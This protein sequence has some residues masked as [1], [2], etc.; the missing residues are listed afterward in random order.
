[1]TMLL[2]AFRVVAL[3]IAAGFMSPAAHA[4]TA[5]DIPI[6]CDVTGANLCDSGVQTQSV[7][8]TASLVTN[9]AYTGDNY[10]CS[11][12]PWVDVRCSFGAVP[13]ASGNATVDSQ[14]AF[15]A[16]INAAAALSQTGSGI[17]YVPPGNYCIGNTTGLGLTTSSP[18]TILGAGQT[19]TIIQA[20]F[21][22]GQC[23]NTTGYSSPNV[24]V[25]TANAQVTIRDV[26]IL[27]PGFTALNTLPTGN[28]L[29]LGVNAV[30]SL[31]EDST[32]E[33]GQFAIVN[34][35]ADA[36][37]Q[38][39]NISYA[40]GTAQVA[41]TNGAFYLRRDKIDLTDQ[42]PHCSSYNP[43][44]GFNPSAWSAN[45]TYNSGNAC[46]L[47]TL[48]IS[49][50]SF[51][52][53]LDNQS[54]CVASGSKPNFLPYGSKIV[55]G[56]CN[57]YLEAPTTFYAFQ[58]DTN[59][60]NSQTATVQFVEH[61]DLSGPYTA[62][63]TTL[64]TGSQATAPQTIDLIVDTIG[65][66]LQ[67]DVELQAGNDVLVLGGQYGGPAFTG[68]AEVYTLGSFLGDLK[69]IGTSCNGGSY[70]IL[71][72]SGSGVT[73]SGNTFGG[74]QVAGIDIGPGSTSFTLEGNTLGS[75]EWVDAGGTT[76]ILISSSGAAQ[77]HYTI[78][79]NICP[80]TAGGAGGPATCFTDNP[81]GSN[82]FIQ[83][84]AGVYGS[85]IGALKGIGYSGE[86][87]TATANGESIAVTV[88]HASPAVVTMTGNTFAARCQDGSS[89]SALCVLPIYFTGLS[90]VGI[91]NNTAYFVDPASISGNNF[92]VATSVANALAATDVATTGTDSGTGIAAMYDTTSGT[93]QPMLEINL[94]GGDWTCSGS[95]YEN[96]V[97]STAP[98]V[99]GAS[100]SPTGSSL[101]AG[102]AESLLNLTF[103]TGAVPNGFAINPTPLSLATQTL[104]ALNAKVTWTGGST[105]PIWQ[106][107]LWCRRT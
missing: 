74:F 46:E 7:A 87:I 22:T 85:Q 38:N 68:G 6:Y 89:N 53:Q 76:G 57:W 52:I 77:S 30:G 35:T 23:G 50:T 14:P 98:T 72:T 67:A 73:I 15:Q 8:N 82:K 59:A 86:L 34:R 66:V 69:V 95:A 56:T 84:D 97:A 102:V 37:V 5:N 54:G 40:Y 10:F 11:G 33:G 42:A 43:P 65:G 36:I 71:H 104:E 3:L 99:M 64:N 62:G 1:M 96:G 19:A 41:S 44:Y 103:T 48:T 12:R 39:A 21:V 92:S 20:G 79:G 27:G 107:Q 16:A 88:S 17:V 26:T 80:P 101:N 51:Y 100:I 61:S 47:Y 60:A 63:V 31:V 25:L 13:G 78:A 18:V 91:S 105:N 94:P 55:D 45:H 32:I 93:T 2:R 4:V 24:T 28:A 106:G 29:T 9:N 81:S 90:G 70:C 83:T 58:A 49:G 75:Q